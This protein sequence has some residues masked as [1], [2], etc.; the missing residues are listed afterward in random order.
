[1]A[2]VNLA[3]IFN[4]HPIAPYIRGAVELEDKG[5]GLVLPH[6]FFSEQMDHFD[7]IG[8]RKRAIAT[9]GIVLDFLTDGTEV[10][11]DC[12]IVRSLNPN[13]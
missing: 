12:S 13:H 1:M 8:R 5:G 2:G 4:N 10:S 11:L 7:R 3:A 9:A 6:R